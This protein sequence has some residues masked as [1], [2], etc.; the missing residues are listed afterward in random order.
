MRYNNWFRSKKNEI[1]NSQIIPRIQPFKNKYS[2]K[3]LNHPPEKEDWK[4]F[5]KNNPTIA[6]VS[7]QNSKREKQVMLLMIPNGDQWHYL[8]VKNW[9]ALLRR[10][11]SKHGGDFYR[12]D[13][14]HSFKTKNKLESRKKACKNKAFCNV[15]MPSEDTKIL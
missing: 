8:A 11:T 4:K 2:W 7:K 14:F 6:R 12:L 1:K 3:G 15:V 10:I 13:C 5:E 9:S